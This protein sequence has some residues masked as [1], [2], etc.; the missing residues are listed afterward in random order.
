MYIMCIQ[1]VACVKITKTINKIFAVFLK[2]STAEKTMFVTEHLNDSED[3]NN[4]VMG[5]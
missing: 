4:F 1:L 5:L 3:E 2:T